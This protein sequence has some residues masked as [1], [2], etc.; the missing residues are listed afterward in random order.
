MAAHVDSMTEQ[1]QQLQ[2][3]LD[4]SLLAHQT[5]VERAKEVMK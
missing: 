2:M 1:N 5:N 3:E 4:Q